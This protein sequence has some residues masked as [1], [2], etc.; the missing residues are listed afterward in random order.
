M[1]RPHRCQLSGPN[2]RD[3]PNGDGGT[4]ACTSSLDR[5]D[6][7]VPYQVT[8]AKKKCPELVLVHVATFK[9]GE[10]EAGYWENPDVNTHKASP[11]TTTS[12]NRLIKPMQVSLDHYRRESMK[13]LQLHRECM[14]PGVE[15]EKASIDEGRS[16]YRVLTWSSPSTSGAAFFDFT[17]AIKETILARYP[18]LSQVP[19]EGLDA[20]LPPP[21][22]ICWNGL[23]NLVQVDPKAEAE[24][25]EKA[26]EDVEGSPGASS[27][28]ESEPTRKQESAATW[29]DLALSI[30][31]EIMMK[32]RAAVKSQLGYTTTAVSPPL[33]FKPEW[34][35]HELHK[36]LA[37]NKMLAKVRLRV[38]LSTLLIHIYASQ[39]VASYKK[40]DQQVS[41]IVI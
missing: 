22:P 3:L 21:P 41:V 38:D 30:G 9:E 19:P 20:P 32:S 16:S 2:V 6:N 7:A 15:V 28:R 1:A 31:A 33:N 10:S 34:E 26:M 13:I 29:H 12:T 27:S 23:G 35:A 25:K 36:G 17:V 5:A 11:L 39:L 14:P 40:Q 4:W 24:E 8:E 37:R 18:H